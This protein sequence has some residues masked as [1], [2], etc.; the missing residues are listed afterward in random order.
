[1]PLTGTWL[2]TTLA[3]DF[4]TETI[5]AIAA[6]PDGRL[7]VGVSNDGLRVYAPDGNGVYT[8]TALHV[9][10]GL[11]SEKVTSLAIFDNELWVGTFDNGISALNLSNGTWH[12]YNMGT[13]PL[14]SNTINRMTVDYGGFS[15]G[16]Y[17]WIATPNGATRYQNGT[18]TTLNTGNSGLNDNIIL[19]IAVQH[20]LIG[21][22]L[23][24]LTWF[25]TSIDVERWNGTSGWTDYGRAN[26]GS[27]F[28]DRAARMVVGNNQDVWFAAQQVNPNAPSGKNA[29]APHIIDPMGVCRFHQDDGS[30]WV[31]NT[32]SPGLPSNI[33]N[34]L[35]VDPAGRVW[36]ALTG[37][38][39]V[40]EPTVVVTETAVA[41]YTTVNSPLFSNQVN[42]VQAVGEAVWFGHAQSPT[43]SQFSP[44][45]LRFTAADMGGAGTPKSLL[46]EA[47]NTW[48]GLGPN[49]AW[50]DANAWNFQSIPGNTAD[51]TSLARDGAG[52]L[53]IG[54]AGN[55]MYALAGPALLTH[56]TTADGLPSDNVRALLTDSDGHLWAATANGLALR[57]NG[58]WLSFQTSN[59]PIV[60]NDL[61]AL[62]LDNT[63]RIWIGTGANS[64]SIL[65]PKAQGGGAWAAEI[66]STTGSWPTINS[67]ATSPSG[68]VW[69]ASP[70][71]VGQWGSGTWT[72]HNAA[73][74]SLPDDNALSLAADPVG[75]V[76]VGT[77]GGLTLRDADLWQN[78]FH[79]TGSMLGSD[80]VAAVGSDGTLWAAA[81]SIVALR[82]ILTKTI[83]SFPPVVNS[84]SPVSGT[85]YTQITINGAHFDD[86]GPQFNRVWFGTQG[87]SGGV[88]AYV[89]SA[90]QTQL[91]VRVPALAHTG[92]IYV[93]SHGFGAESSSDFTV[94]PHISSVNPTCAALGQVIR[95][96]GDGWNDPGLVWV[97]IGNGNWRQTDY[98]DPYLIRQFVRP[99]DTAGP[100]SVR[101]GL[102]GPIATSAQALTIGAPQVAGTFIQQG[103][104]GVQMI[105]GKRTLVQVTLQTGS[106]CKAR[107]DG[108]TLEWKWKTNTTSTGA[109]ASFAGKSGLDVFTAAPSQVS[110]N[111]AVNFVLEGMSSLKPLSSFDGVRI[112]L[113]NGPVNLVTY[114]VP[115]SS[116]N[117]KDNGSKNHLIVVPIFPPGYTSQQFA[118]FLRIE[119]KGLWDYARAYPQRDGAYW[120]WIS[121]A[122]FYFE[123]ASVNLNT[124]DFDRVRGKVENMRDLINDQDQGGLNQAYALVAAE[125]HVTGPSGK[126]VAWCG[127]PFS[128]CSQSTSV[129]FNHDDSKNL[130]GMTPT[131]LQETIHS[132]QWVKSSSPNHAQYNEWHSRYDEGQWGDVKDCKANQ[133]F[134]QAL[135]DQLGFAARVLSLQRWMPPYEFSQAGCGDANQMPR[136]AM[137]YAPV[138]MDFNTF[139]EPLDYAFVLSQID[140][141]ALARQLTAPLAV[142]RSLRLNGGIDAADHVTVTLSYILTTT[143][144]LTP[145]SPM[146]N[147]H[148]LLRDNGNNVLHDQ[149]FDLA[150]QST[151]G[152]PVQTALFALRV[153]FPDGTTTAEIR[154]GSLLLWSKTVSA[155]APAVNI[156]SPAGGSYPADGVVPVSWTASDQDGDVLQFYLQYSADN[157]VTWKPVAV[158]LTGTSFNWR[159]GF[160]LASVTARLRLTASDGF[161][162]TSAVS[163]PFTLTARSPVAFV[164]EP[165]D[166]QAFVEG[167][168][169]QFTG[170]SATS[171]G[172]DAGTFDWQR[173]GAAIGSGPIITDTLDQAGVHT[174]TL[175]VAD[176]GLTG[177]DSIT[178]TVRPD[179]DGD[180]MPDDWE[181]AH[182]LSPLDPTDAAADADSDRLTN[183]HEYQVGA[184]PRDS[185]TDNDGASD[186]AEVTAGTDPLRADE[187]PAI[188]PVLNVGSGDLTFTTIAG[189]PSPAPLSFWVSN[190][191]TA[192]LNWSAASDAPW[193]QVAPLSGA[194][195]TPITLTLSTQAMPVGYHVG[196]VTFS[197]AG[198]AGSPR[199][200]TVAVDVVRADGMR[201]V[202][203]PLIRR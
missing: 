198:A 112:T 186:G 64:L 59:S 182:S 33:V 69:A 194:A 45:W 92:K 162:T 181:L 43:L 18:W 197:A 170:G 48:V 110:V 152:D 9:I 66:I 166:G 107:I 79:V 70:A 202:Y 179:F 11:A 104:Q 183:L 180:G 106:A 36:A 136:S 49:I 171:S 46:V 38:A 32:S 77:A 84:F 187:K 34:D 164:R 169:V 161:N 7:F 154:H 25:S 185:D 140:Q 103:V 167:A 93:L 97:K 123:E 130:P 20:V 39:A 30:W 75:R 60:S 67:L 78:A 131:M 86:R 2:T 148:L 44:N 54:T 142:A 151:H 108:G 91:V 61:R 51:V 81:G 139:L 5:T 6:A 73:N 173:N 121:K 87:G 125:L 12:P 58:Y 115:A 98:R 188:T 105:W 137:S 141:L 184:D 55:G 19:D 146:G 101:I 144:D 175:R 195:P 35:S 109:Y 145:S 114:D 41:I 117:F 127:M 27:C 95:I 23:F 17:I 199:I 53:W 89:L 72:L 120:D 201:L 158:Q 50:R 63:D 100:I 165:N 191:G 28:M 192:M 80:R 134:R 16:F 193:L 47:A 90:S 83:G 147:Y 76:W 150:F 40:L 174:F 68:E 203:L 177:A 149:V 96:F 8:W 13:V 52:T 153:P 88:E 156:V 1:L 135:I 3:S 24:T 62:T 21:P 26:T 126:A 189:G 119:D 65:N 176:H 22:S 190:G 138:D 94:L 71:G 159:P 160:A 42:S 74:F 56:Y 102:S 155:H 196:H 143:T 118:D 128:D 129:G 99:G 29:N 31:Y 10:D 200:L 168:T 133:T 157:G 85:P 113:K 14:P 172:Y 111:T 132:F 15:V 116:F 122:I 163:A 82:G 37:G 4:G 57:G 178:L 124:G